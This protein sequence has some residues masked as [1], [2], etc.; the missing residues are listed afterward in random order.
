MKKIEIKNITKKN[1]ILSKGIIADS[2][3]TRLKGLIGRKELGID[4][5]ICIKP[6]KSVHTF[7]M[8]FSIDVVF[9]DRNG[10]VCEIVKNMEPYKVSEYISKA[11]YVIEFSAGNA[12]RFGLEIGDIIELRKREKL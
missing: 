7:F 3:F 11:S 10:F 1:T 4:E 2:F 9:I 6:C 12:D 8:S 5:A